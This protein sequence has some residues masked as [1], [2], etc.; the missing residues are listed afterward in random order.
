MPEFTQV[1]KSRIQAELRLYHSADSL[2]LMAA[3]KGRWIWKV[4]KSDMQLSRG[5]VKEN[6]IWSPMIEE[7]HCLMDV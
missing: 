2:H 3:R 5:K 1:R 6:N 7:A 4:K